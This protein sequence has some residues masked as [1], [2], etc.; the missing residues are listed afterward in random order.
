MSKAKYEA[1]IKVQLEGLKKISDLENK[2]NKV[3]KLADRLSRKRIDLNSGGRGSQRDASGIA[4]RKAN[5]AIRGFINGSSKFGKSVSSINSQLGDFNELLNMTAVKGTGLFDKQTTAVKDLATV[6]TQAT[7][8][9]KELAEAQEN[10]RR[11]ADPTRSGTVVEAEVR[12]R[13]RRSRVRRGRERQQRFERARSSAL[14]GGAFPL[15]FGQGVGA[16]ALGAAGGFSGGL[17]GGQMGFALSLVGTSVGAAID[18]LVKDTAK[19]GQALSPLSQDIQTVTT[20]L[21]LQ[22]SAQAAQLQLLEQVKGKTAAFNV[23]MQLMANDLGQKGVNALKVFGE[24]A[25]ILGGEFKLAITRLQ[26]FTASF[27]NFVLR[28]TGAKKTLDKAD[29]ERTI[30]FAAIRGDEEAKAIQAEQKRID[31]APLIRRTGGMGS[32][33][34]GQSQEIMQD[35]NVLNRRKEIFTLLNKERVALSNINQESLSLSQTLEDEVKLREKTERLIREGNSK[36]LAEKLAKNEVIF[37]KAKENIQMQ[38]T[39]NEILNK[40]ELDKLKIKEKNNK[41]STEEKKRLDDLRQIQQFLNNQKK[42]QN[43]LLDEANDKT[44]TLNDETKKLKITREEIANLLANET[45]N[46]VMGLIEGTKTLSESLSGIARQLA[47]L[48]LNRAFGAFFGNIFGGE[49]GGYLR[50]GSFKAFQ[51]GGVVSSPTL[52]MIGEGG[53]PEYV[54]PSSKMDGAMAR[55]SAGARGGAVIPGGS[56]ASGTVAGSSGNT[57]VEYTG[58]VLNFNGDEYVPKDSVP[59]II[60]AA[61]QQGAS[62]GQA[63]VMSTLKNSRSQRSKIGI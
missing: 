6:F 12:N 37:E 17:M 55:Y 52:G 39:L 59:R 35:Q 36:T 61:A 16:S 26:A 58:P 50:S 19:L 18:G 5:D 45:T 8:R 11:T 32:T 3:D 7:A 1:A 15:L 2:L 38:I 25:R 31:Q 44:R 23:A 27:L 57:I 28:V 56:G 54:I 40:D 41:L 62:M 4:S 43:D 60:S 9:A 22:N 51:Y 63:K 14:I 49:Q 33:F 29:Q 42:R 30:N 53:E 46:A 13:N 10:L 20:S 21:G 47:S 34:M 48:F 24:S